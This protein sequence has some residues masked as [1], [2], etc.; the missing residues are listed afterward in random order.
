MIARQTPVANDLRLV[1]SLLA[2]AQSGCFVAGQFVPIGNQLREIDS[3]VLGYHA[4]AE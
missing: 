4:L 3:G 2:L 1:L